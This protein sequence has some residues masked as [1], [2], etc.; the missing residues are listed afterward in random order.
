MP[1]ETLLTPEGHKAEV[2][3]RV[4]DQRAPREVAERIKEAREFGDISENSEYDD[5]KNEQA[6]L[7]KQ[8]SDLEEK[9]RAA[10]VIDQSKST[11][12][13]VSVGS[14]VHVKDQKTDKSA[15]YKIV[16]P[17]RPTRPTS[18]LSNES[19]VGKALLGKKRGDTVSVPVPRG[20]ARKLKITKIEAA[21]AAA[22]GRGRGSAASTDERRAKLERLRGAGIDPFPHYLP[23]RRRRRSDARGATRLEDGE[24]T[25]AIPRRRPA[26]PAAAGTAA[27]R[28]S[29]SSTAPA[30]SRCRPARTSS[31]TSRSSC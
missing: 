29:T 20:P 30:R 11:T 23:R 22:R 28:S 1:R 19:P 17:P 16:G 10:S 24:E 21:V 12:D 5:A 31:A 7:E 25:D 18:K 8:I 14:T 4:P 2:Q 6:M 9:L 3:D 27:R 26:S 13:A 15:K